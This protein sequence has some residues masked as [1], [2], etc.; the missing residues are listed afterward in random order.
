[1]NIRIEKKEGFSFY[2]ITRR[3]STVEG[4]N[5]DLIPKFW[6]EVLSNG[7]FDKMVEHRLSEK[8]LGVCMP[9]IEG[10]ENQFDYVIGA[11]TDTPIEGYDHF[12]VPE[13]LWAIFE[14]VGPVNPTL[15]NAWK[16]IHSDWFPSNAYEHVPL[17]ELEVYLPEDVNR[18]DYLTEIWIPIK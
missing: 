8:S 6:D 9:M 18:E 13:T 15:Q 16:W 10:A 17:P 1:M 7:T 5:F 12:E 14:V 2:G 3:V 4:A 11:F